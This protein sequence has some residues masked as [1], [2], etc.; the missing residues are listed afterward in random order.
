MNP[1]LGR[2]GTPLFRVFAG[3]AFLALTGTIGTAQ[4]GQGPQ[5]TIKDL[6]TL[7]GLS[8]QGVA[9]NN[10]GQ[11]AGTIV[12]SDRA[13]ERAFFWDGT[14]IHD[15]GDLG[16]GV[17]I[18]TGINQSG[19]I[20]GTSLPASGDFRYFVWN[21]TSM[22]AL[23]L[24]IGEVDGFGGI[25]DLAQVAGNCSATGNYFH[26]C[27]WD[28]SFTQDIGTLQGGYSFGTG[29][30]NSGDMTGWSWAFDPRTSGFQNHAF[31][32][33]G[34]TMQDLGTLGRLN[35]VG[36][37]INATGQIAGTVSGSLGGNLLTSAFIWDGSTMRELG[38]FG[39]SYG[40]GIN[41][42]GEVVGYL[43]GSSYS[44]AFFWDG[45]T[46]WDLNTQVVDMSGWTELTSAQAINDRGQI[47]GYGT[48]G[49]EV[50]AFLLTPVSSGGT[51]T[52]TTNLEA[53]SFTITG[54]INYD[55][56]GQSFTQIGA[57]AG[58]YTITYHLVACYSTPVSE[59]A[60]LTPGETLAF[61]QGTRGSYSGSASLW[62]D[63]QPIAASSATFSVVPNIPGLPT[64][65]PYSFPVQVRNIAPVNI[66]VSFGAV[67]G[68][69][70]PSPK[71]VAP[72]ANCA[73][74]VTGTYVASD[75]VPKASLTVQTNR[76]SY[77][78]HENNQFGRVLGSKELA[79]LAPG[80]YW[81]QF[82]PVKGYFTPLSQL[83]RIAAGEAAEVGGVY[84]RLAIVAFTGYGNGLCKQYFSNQIANG[85]RTCKQYYIQYPDAKDG[86]NVPGLGMTR[87]L[88]TLKSS[89]AYSKYFEPLQAAAFTFFTQ[90][91]G[92]PTSAPSTAS[93]T[94]QDHLEAAAWVKTLALSD[95][96]R[97]MIIGHSY[98]GFRA[99][100][101]VEQLRTQLGITSDRLI[102]VDPVDWGLC[103]MSGAWE[104]LV[105]D[106]VCDQ[107]EQK[108]A[109]PSAAT[110]SFGFRQLIGLNVLGVPVFPLM[111]YPLADPSPTSIVAKSHTEIDDDDSVLQSVIDEAVARSADVRVL[112]ASIAK[113]ISTRRIY[114]PLRFG[115]IGQGTIDGIKITAA[116]L[117]GSLALNIPASP[118]PAI[119]AGGS[120][121]VIWFEFPS[122]AG[123]AGSATNYF[124]VGGSTADGSAFSFVYKGN[125][126]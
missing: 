86:L 100:I 90:G 84:R 42:R 25:N 82:T 37:A 74:S 48:I 69:I 78:V 118:L 3:L 56:S 93:G 51:I 39:P 122:T 14:S 17:A 53:A 58:T 38:A 73:I 54:P 105:H 12:T 55:G 10:A 67:P 113:P 41:D 87:V 11:V 32:W 119:Q 110:G 46:V 45:S 21:G 101:F 23:G 65:Y 35:S 72:D 4:S 112:S 89:T 71:S 22:Q 123:I 103:H 31:F 1:V 47:T 88:W 96:D 61:G 2:D 34:T 15:I 40:N 36:S 102:T 8:S 20:S 121:N 33:N 75:T 99:N 108:Y 114:V 18:A 116:A 115:V 77:S 7:G 111:G 126:F 76:G 66:T 26:A 120:G 28:G 125:P 79:S 97:V 27:F 98:G 9:I 124:V 19:Q 13:A 50:H 49:G 95:T 91:N 106:G 16:G 92:T 94:Q 117:N 24:P 70:A 83:I 62:I 6:G 85:A 43:S 5:F 109:R 107:V 44:H 30:N 59:T 104:Q 80:T 29:I 60:V 68:F 57:P 52:V 81:V 64:T 63:V